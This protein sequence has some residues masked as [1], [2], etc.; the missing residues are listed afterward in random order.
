MISWSVDRVF[1]RS[2]D[3]LINRA[4]DWFTDWVITGRSLAYRLFVQ[5]LVEANAT[6]NIIIAYLLSFFRQSNSLT[7]DVRRQLKWIKRR[8][9]VNKDINSLSHRRSGCDFTTVKVSSA[10]PMQVNIVV[11]DGLVPI[12]RQATRNYHD[13]LVWSW[14]RL[15]RAYTCQRMFGVMQRHIKWPPVTTCCGRLTLPMLVPYV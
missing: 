2:I 1:D 8:E 4:S 10:G 12:W 5:Q 14:T 6:E 7:K 15:H 11:A 9:N 13:D 3:W